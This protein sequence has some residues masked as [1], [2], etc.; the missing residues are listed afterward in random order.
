MSSMETQARLAFARTLIEEAGRVA[1]DYFERREELVVEHKGLQDVVSIADQAVELLVREKIASAFP[2]DG[3][4][5]EEDAARDIANFKANATERIWVVDPIDGTALFLNG[6]PSWC[7]SIALLVQ[8]EI[9]LGL[10]YDPCS[11]ELFCAQRGAGATLNDK[12]ISVANVQQITEGM[13]GVGFSHR[14]K[15]ET[16]LHFLDKLL[17]QGGMYVRSGSGALSLA[18]VAAGR[19]IAYY[20]PHINAWDCLAGILL[21]EEAGGWV[22]DFLAD[23]GLAEGNPILCGA[24]PLQQ[25]LQSYCLEGY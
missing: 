8:G 14:V 7:I 2:E 4:L 5:G 18:Y 13:T 24:K 1:H 10:I 6:I 16:C 20:E 9:E 12:A 17:H 3:F 19:L 15:P 21:I 22:N 25:A 11:R 23:E